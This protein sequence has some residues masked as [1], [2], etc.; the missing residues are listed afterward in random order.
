M[1]EKG[2]SFRDTLALTVRGDGL[3]I[4]PYIIVHTYKTASKASGRRCRADEEPVRGMNVPRMIDYI[5][6]IALYVQETSLL[7]MDKL[8]SHT[9]GQVRKHILKKK[10]PSGEQMFI[11]I[12]LPAKIAF[13]ISPLDMGAISSFKSHYHKLD[14]ATVTLKLRARS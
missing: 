4:P 9:S 12:F 1:E 14:R 11:P 10:T 7:I 3:D 5:D 6:H 13:L 8:S 2:D